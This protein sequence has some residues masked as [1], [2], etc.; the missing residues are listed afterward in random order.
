M[1]PDGCE[2]VATGTVGLEHVGDPNSIVFAG[3]TFAPV[4]RPQQICPARAV[5]VLSVHAVAI[6]KGRVSSRS[7][8]PVNRSAAVRATVGFAAWF[9]KNSFVPS[10]PKQELPFTHA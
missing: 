4:V 2:T 5:P 10:A 8:P 7:V 3:G 9:T 6:V 1:G